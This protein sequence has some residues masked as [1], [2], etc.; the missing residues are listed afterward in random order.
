MK[1]KFFANYL[2]RC[3]IAE[4]ETNDIILDTHTLDP[5]VA[6]ACELAVDLHNKVVDAYEEHIG[7]LTDLDK[8]DVAATK[9]GIKGSV[10][11]AG[12]GL[13]AAIM[14][15]PLLDL[16]APN[17]VEC[18]FNVLDPKVGHRV[19]LAYTIQR[20]TGKTPHEKRQ[21]AEAEA[22]RLRAVLADLNIEHQRTGFAPPA[23]S[24][25]E[26]C[27]ACRRD[28]AIKPEGQR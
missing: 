2:G 6:K 15:K 27:P 18:R 17:Y 24:C 3:G 26:W 13:M 11:G 10:Q 9:M 16:D 22:E 23:P 21:E 1:W 28:A 5:T 7:T 4:V 20:V 12:A 8:F 14:S 25:V 19:E